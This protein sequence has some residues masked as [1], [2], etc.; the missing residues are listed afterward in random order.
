MSVK[1]IEKK[2]DKKINILYIIIIN[3]KESHF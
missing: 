1:Q 3:L 2:L